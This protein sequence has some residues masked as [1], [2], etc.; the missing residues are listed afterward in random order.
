MTEMKKAY[1]IIILVIAAL[2]ASGACLA[3][4]PTKMSYQGKLTTSSGAVAPDGTYSMVFRLYFLQTGGTPLWTETQSVETRGGVFSVFLGSVTPLASTAFSGTTWLSVEVNGSLITP[5]AQI[6]SVGYAMRAAVAETVPDGSITSAKIAS[7]AVTYSQIASNSVSA[8]KLQM[9]AVTSAKINAGAVTADKL[10]PAVFTALGLTARSVD[11]IFNVKDYGAVGDGVADDTTA[12]QNALNAASARGGG[13]AYA[14]TGSY[15]IATHLNVPANVTLQGVWRAP[16]A[17]NVWR[18]NVGTL[19]LAY[20]GE[21]SPD[22][23]AFITLN[24]NSTLK[25]VAI[26]YSEQ[27]ADLSQPRQYPYTISIPYTNPQTTLTD[28]PSVIDCTV[29]NPYQCL[30]FAGAGRHYVHGLYGQP[31]YMGIWVDMCYDVGR[32]ENVH[33][34]P[35]FTEGLPQYQALADWQRANGTGILFSRS[36]WQYVLN[37]YVNGYNYGYHFVQSSGGANQEILPGGNTSGNFAGIA[38]NNCNTA[39]LIDRCSPTGVLIASGEFVASDRA[40]Y[41]TLSASD[42][43]VGMTNCSFW[44]ASNRI[45]TVASGMLSLSDCSM[46]DWNKNN[47]GEYAVVATGGRV[48]ISG[49]SFATNG[50][51]ASIGSG[52]TGAIIIGNQGVATSEIS[53]SAGSKCITANN[54]P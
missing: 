35:Y 38:A 25:G 1:I 21:G 9:N 22:G 15:K 5:R 20:E 30:R 10:D 26:F 31:L 51:V 43:V 32:I 48:S 40:V 11:A 16:T 33:F 44:G 37:T 52:I 7:R 47:N 24:E 50:N 53:N 42:S 19:L 17:N 36:D 2:V 23:T 41:F 4:V 12:F 6:V 49:C 14:P 18:D 28:N 13:I 46:R 34:G 27:T 54:V 39:V 3:S 45:A 8:D 29:I